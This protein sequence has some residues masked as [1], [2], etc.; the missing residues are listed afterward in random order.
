[1]NKEVPPEVKE[2]LTEA[3]KLAEKARSGGKGFMA[4]FT[5]GHSGEYAENAADLYS[6]AG[7]LLKAEQHWKQAAEAFIKAAELHELDA[8]SKEEGARKRVSAAS[9]YRKYDAASAIAQLER[10]VQVYLRA[11]RFSLV[12]TY[13]KESAEIWEGEGNWGEA[14][15]C[16]E[17]AAKRFEAE[18]Q[19]A[20]AQGCLAKAALAYGWMGNWT[21]SSELY[22]RIAEACASDHLRRFSAKDYYFR[23]IL[24][25]F[26][27]G[28]VVGGKKKAEG[29][30]E[31]GREL[32]LSM[33]IAEALESSDVEAFSQAVANYDQVASLDDWKTHVLLEIKKTIDAEPSLA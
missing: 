7:N 23:A 22:T 24:C 25:A 19:P 8:D 30:L 4:F 6:K 28:D 10:A 5:G 9:C 14:A 18:D 17:K 32:Q 15:G 26:A 29:L 20:M 11:G 33:A 27:D 16:Y 13:E 31:K 2:L 12:A 21:C 1:M 3:D